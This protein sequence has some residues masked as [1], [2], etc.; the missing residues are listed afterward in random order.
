MSKQSIITKST[1]ICYKIRFKESSLW[2]DITI[3]ENDKAGRLQIASDFGDWQYYWGSCGESF[4]KFLIGLDIHYTAGKFGADRWF[5]LD[6][7]IAL[8]KSQVE[9]YLSYEGYLSKTNLKT[10]KEKLSAEIKILEHEVSCKDE[11]IHKMWDSE[12]LI[13][14]F[15]SSPD[16]ITGIEPLFQRFWDEIW[17]VFVQELKK[18][19]L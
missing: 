7:T 14:M 11:F 8:L 18:E 12:E 10:L 15:D 13:K 17:S 9:E 16:I 19:I 1:V 5:D 6:K 3:D 4:K 2:A